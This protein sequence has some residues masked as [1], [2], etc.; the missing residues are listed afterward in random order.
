MISRMNPGPE[1]YLH[2]KYDYFYFGYN[3]AGNTQKHMNFDEPKIEPDSNWLGIFDFM[4]KGDPRVYW[5]VINQLRRA[6]GNKKKL[7][8][9]KTE[10][11]K[12][13]RNQTINRIFSKVENVIEARLGKNFDNFSSTV[14]HHKTKFNTFSETVTTPIIKQ[15][16]TDRSPTKQAGD[17][18]FQNEQTTRISTTNPYLTKLGLALGHKV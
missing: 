2:Q 9:V 15:M 18:S 13:K 3:Y 1:S 4:F 8:R 11:Q 7:T 6:L 16:N 14:K 5:F 12:E 17:C 10:E